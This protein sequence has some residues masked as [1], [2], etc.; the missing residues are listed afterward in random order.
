MTA[1]KGSNPFTTEESSASEKFHTKII[2][3]VFEELKNKDPNWNKRHSVS[4][5]EL[6]GRPCKYALDFRKGKKNGKSLTYEADGGWIYYKDYLVGVAENKY[7]S[8]VTNAMERVHRYR[9]LIPDE[10]LFV[11]INAPLKSAVAK[12]VESLDFFG[13]FLVVNVD[14]EDDFRKEVVK[15]FNNMKET[16]LNKKLNET[17]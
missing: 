7:Q 8:N 11:S 17:T 12:V 9:G 4:L 2:H 5:E 1:P 16:V 13:V 14:D 10:N 15:W 3:E 6:F